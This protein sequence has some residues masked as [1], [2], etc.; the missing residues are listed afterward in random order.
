MGQMINISSGQDVEAY[1]AT[2]NGEI[3]GAIIV[4]HEVWGLADHIKDVADRYAGEGYIAIAPELLD[5]LDFGSN[6]VAQLQK[7]LFNPEKRNATQPILR[8]LMAPINVPE[9]GQKT[10]NRLKDCFDY[11]YNL[12]QVNKKVAVT[13]FCFGGTYSY[14]LAINE[15][16]LKIAMPFYGHA[17]QPTSELASINCPVRA[18]YGVND[19]NLIDKLPDLQER[20]K[21]AGVDYES[22]VYDNAGHAFFNDTNPYA[23]NEVAAV[24]SWNIVLEELDKA[25]N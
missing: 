21:Q 6:D 4:I 11:L 19:Q 18:F 12:P 15:P 17:D 9:F 25:F 3:K 8:E 16:R 20:M 5:D 14:C 2:P 13:G 24:D 10:T 23:Y 1:L 22:K 7:D